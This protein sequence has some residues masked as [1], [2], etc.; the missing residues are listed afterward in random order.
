MNYFRSSLSINCLNYFFTLAGETNKEL[1]TQT[2]QAAREASNDIV[3]QLDDE[4][5][6]TSKDDG[7]LFFD[8]NFLFDS[9]NLFFHGNLSI[10][11]LNLFF[12]NYFFN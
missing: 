7:N 1:S 3:D 10:N 12:Y 9:S 8:I 4:A 5:N 2:E 6:K 11:C